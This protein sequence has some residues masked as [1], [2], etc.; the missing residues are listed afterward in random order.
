MF[1]LN[2]NSIIRSIHY[3]STVQDAIMPVPLVDGDCVADVLQAVDGAVLHAVPQ[4]VT[5]H[6]HAPVVLENYSHN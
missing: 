3:K 1:L 2:K 4:V 6:A 5:A